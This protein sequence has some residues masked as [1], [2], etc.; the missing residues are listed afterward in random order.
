[1]TNLEAALGCAQLEQ[2]SD[3]VAR[4][5]RIQRSYTEALCPT[6]AW[7]APPAA[8]A[9]GSGWIATLLFRGSR[10]ETMHRIRA[11]LRAA[12]VDVRPFWQPVHMQ[13]P[14][15][16]AP[17]SDCPASEDLWW[18]ILTLPTTPTLTDP[19]LDYVARSVRAA[20]AAAS[21]T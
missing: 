3:F 17:R 13:P 14:Y 12:D 7:D 11:H 6:G 20:T 18:R 4:R 10:P 2:L 9:T 5:R 21:G 19:E 1:M 16:T 15:A 8:A